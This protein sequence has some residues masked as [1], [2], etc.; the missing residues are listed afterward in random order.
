MKSIDITQRNTC[1]WLST[2]TGWTTLVD[3]ENAEDDEKVRAVPIATSEKWKELGE[4]RGS[5]IPFLFMNDASR[6][7]SPLSLYGAENVA[8][9]KSVA[10]KYDPS[11]TFQTLQG[12]GFLLSKV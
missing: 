8:R 5:Y 4:Q 11:H 7:Q 1:Q 6:D 9:L 12:N 3:W 10:S 2:H